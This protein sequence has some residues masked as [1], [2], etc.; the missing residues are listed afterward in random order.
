MNGNN[1][2]LAK[3]LAFLITAY[4]DHAEE[5]GR[6]TNLFLKDPEKARLELSK[7]RRANPDIRFPKDLEILIEQELQ[8][9]QKNVL[10]EEQEEKDLKKPSEKDMQKIY[11]VKKKVPPTPAERYK[12]AIEDEFIEKQSNERTSKDYLKEKELSE[13]EVF[14]QWYKENTK[15]FG[16]KSPSV[17]ES[18]AYKESEEFKKKVAENADR[19]YKERFSAEITSFITIEKY[20]IYDDPNE[21]PVL[22]EFKKIL[23]EAEK[24]PTE[25]AKKTKEA[26]LRDIS[27]SYQQKALSYSNDVPEIQTFLTGANKESLLSPSIISSAA[28]NNS[29]ANTTSDQYLDNQREE[30]QEPS[31]E[32]SRSSSSNQQRRDSRR[33]RKKSSTP[34]THSPKSPKK[35][36]FKN[37]KAGKK[38]LENIGKKILSQI[39]QKAVV[40]FGAA[41]WEVWAV[42]LLI[43]GLLFLFLF[44]LDEV[45]ETYHQGGTIYISKS[46]DKE[47]VVNPPADPNYLTALST[48]Q[49]IT[50]TISVSFSQEADAITVTDPIPE[51]ALFVS[52]SDNPVL[53]DAQGNTIK[54]PSQYSLVSKVEWFISAYGDSAS[55]DDILN[56]TYKK[57]AG[58]TGGK[59]TESAVLATWLDKKL[60]GSGLA[61]QGSTFTFLSAKYNIP[62]ELALGMFWHEAQWATTG[63]NPEANNPG[64]LSNGT[65]TT[66]TPKCAKWST[67]PNQV[68]SKSTSKNT[69][70]VYPS[71][72]D[73]IEAYFKLLSTNYREAVD[74]FIQT[75]D[76][77]QVIA[78]YYSSA[79]D[80][81]G[82][83][84]SQYIININSKVKELKDS[85]SKDGV[86]LS[87]V[88]TSGAGIGLTKTF[89][90]VLRPKPDTKDTYIANVASVYTIGGTNSGATISSPKTTQEWIDTF[91][92]AALISQVPWEFLASIAIQ[93]SAL[94]SDF[95]TCSYYSPA[96]GGHVLV[97]GNGLRP[98]AED[99]TS[100]ATIAQKL[101]IPLNT[102]VSCNPK[103][104]NGGAM[105]YTQIMPDEMIALGSA[106]ESILSHYPNPWNATDAVILTGII[107]KNKMKIGINSPMPEIYSIMFEAAWRYYGYHPTTE[108][109]KFYPNA[110]MARY[111]EIKA[112]QTLP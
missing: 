106:A 96:P 8:Q 18:A 4:P 86:S 39:G 70:C 37:S 7:Y 9:N 33:E 97:P 38:A 14:N 83:N 68:G 21:D 103:G 24:Q 99:A 62:I 12:K 26:A 36:P 73:G 80:E 65:I 32:D 56:Y 88:G 31:Q 95:G 71:M 91:K 30:N 50:Y 108:V 90:L 61:G 6:I 45:E 19:R 82:G 87:A 1:N 10:N 79:N 13:K 57:A 11:L 101:N 59:A 109:G 63:I 107:L 22:K 41:T 84:A 42:I 2:P 100:F 105:G 112:K 48:P 47:A 102:G 51:N 111:Q 49:D 60:A 54:D 15:L 34:S 20:K 104:S 28:E 110:V 72:Q 77:S 74:Y 94:G 25:D 66:G 27:E 93:E 92:Q 85:A 46:A 55:P 98:K 81:S 75:A 67:T 53:K 78:K 69:Y 44:L 29:E 43:I 35:S 5:L 3:A 16:K 17:E 52:A 58:V 64:D 40:A 76:P 23:A 89:T